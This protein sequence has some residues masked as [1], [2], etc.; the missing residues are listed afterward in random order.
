MLSCVECVYIPISNA[1]AADMKMGA[2]CQLHAIRG[3]LAGLCLNGSNNDND[4]I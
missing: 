3:V 1:I 2:I 4:N